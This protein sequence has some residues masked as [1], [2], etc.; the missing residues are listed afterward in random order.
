MTNLDILRN[1][2]YTGFGISTSPLRTER[3]SVGGRV[4]LFFGLHPP[5]LTRCLE[6]GAWQAL[7]ASIYTE[8]VEKN[9]LSK[10]IPEEVF[11]QALRSVL[12]IPAWI[13][14]LMPVLTS[15]MCTF[16]RDPN[17]KT[18]IYCHGN[19]AARMT[20][21]RRWTNR[22]VSTALDHNFIIFDY[23][24]FGD[25]TGV[26]SQEGLLTDART[27]WD[28]VTVEKGVPSEK[29]GLMGQ[30]LGTGVAAGFASRLAKEGGCISLSLSLPERRRVWPEHLWRVCVAGIRPQAVILVAAYSSISNLLL[31]YR[32][33]KFLPILAPLGTIPH[34]Q[35]EDNAFRPVCPVSVMTDVR[36][37]LQACFLVSCRPALI[38]SA[39]SG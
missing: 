18:L 24:G 5:V 16:T 3:R 34:A 28:Y 12:T 36:L 39:S 7:P 27:V 11:D 35:R 30:S 23:R 2:K 20:G 13:F 19:S 25:S 22:M 10:P 8:Y 37:S 1:P 33:F 17:H 29:V 14:D 31:T 9:G 32:L 15:L 6:T 26:P 4:P 21:H 38:P